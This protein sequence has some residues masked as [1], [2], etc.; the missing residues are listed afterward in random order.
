MVEVVRGGNTLVLELEVAPE[1]LALLIVSSLPI[2]LVLLLLLLLSDGGG[3]GSALEKSARALLKE[4][5][6]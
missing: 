1:A 3:G 5:I 2:L 6:S 4:S